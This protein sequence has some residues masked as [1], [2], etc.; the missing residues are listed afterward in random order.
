MKEI[1]R[2]AGYSTLRPFAAVLHELTLLVKLIEDAAIATGHHSRSRCSTFTHKN[3]PFVDCYKYVT[4]LVLFVGV[5]NYFQ[6][7][8]H[9][10]TKLFVAISCL[11][12][13]LLMGDLANSR[14]QKYVPSEL[15]PFPK[16]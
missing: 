4:F 11:F 9:Y 13:T 5:L 15:W 1:R 2:I 16:H 7:I 3:I 6:V 8:F 10:L 12:S 14:S